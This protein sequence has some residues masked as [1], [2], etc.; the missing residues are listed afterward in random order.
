MVGKKEGKYLVFYLDNGKTC[1]YDLSTGEQIGVRGQRVETLN[2]VMNFC[3]IK[4]G[5]ESI[6]DINYQNFLRFVMC[7][8]YN[9]YRYYYSFGSLLK[10]LPDFKDYE[11]YF[12]M[13]FPEESFLLNRRTP[14]VA[15]S[16][17]ARF[18]D[19]PIGCL[20]LMKKHKITASD[21][22][23]NTYKKFPN[24]VNLIFSLDYRSLTSKDLYN[25][26][27]WT[28]YTDYNLYNPRAD[29]DVMSFAH[30]FN[31]DIRSLFRYF[32]YLKTYEALGISVIMGRYND[33]MNMMSCIS[34]RFE[35]YPKNLLTTEQIVIRRY[36]SLKQKFDEEKFAK[37]YRK[38][39][40]WSYGNFMVICPK[41]TE[42]IKNEG[43]HQGNC[44][45][46]YID[47]VIRGACNIVFLRKKSEPDESWITIEI[48]DNTVVQALGAFNGELDT[49]QQAVLD[50]YEEYLSTLD[51][52]K[53]AS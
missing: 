41:T 31:L 17:I 51:K 1:K 40:E 38:E 8:D 35:K 50:I 29:R 22:F 27:T 21:V 15:P 49:I 9:N 4:E 47:K 25:I 32:D 12:A 10:R 30:T 13:G 18:K 33:Y 39:L 3:S 16:H 44:V 46:S 5:I 7:V 37:T 11:G 48:E 43:T 14:L 23:V 20:N 36:N 2:H 34:P 26:L 52:V 6:E 53:E 24:E 42:E 19:V 45:A 28:M